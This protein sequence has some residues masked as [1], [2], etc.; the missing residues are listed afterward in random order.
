M[1]PIESQDID[2]T[3]EAPKKKQSKEERAAIQRAYYFAHKEEWRK[4]GREWHA[5]NR[6]KSREMS[7][8]YRDKSK[9]DPAYL[10]RRKAHD[11]KNYERHGERIRANSKAYREAHPQETTAAAIKWRQE[12]PER[13]KEIVN[14][15]YAKHKTRY[16][17]ERKARRDQKNAYMEQYRE[18]NREKVKESARI[19]YEKHFKK[20][21]EAFKHNYEANKEKYFAAVRNR[22]AKIKS[23]PGTH[24]KADILELYYNQNCRCRA[25]NCEISDI[26]GTTKFHVDHII[27]ISKNGSNGIENLQLLCRTC[28]LSKHTQ[29]FEEWMKHKGYSLTPISEQEN[30]LDPNH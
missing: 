5:A 2:W 24:T 14:A 8:A 21:Q 12:H 28:N 1:K 16:A 26:S 15:S 9:E 29:N 27:P 19:S 3:V 11:R 13:I 20:R 25:C 22:N 23:L 4:K 7:K 18:E 30:P 6:D 17:E 10:E